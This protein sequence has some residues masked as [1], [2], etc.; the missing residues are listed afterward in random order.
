L[1]CAKKAL[2]LEVSESVFYTDNTVLYQPSSIRCQSMSS[3]ARLSTAFAD[4]TM[5][6]IWADETDHRIKPRRTLKT[7]LIGLALSLFTHMLLV[8]ILPKPETKIDM[9]EAGGQGPLQVVIAPEEK[10]SPPPAAS[11]PP[12][13]PQRPPSAPRVIAVPKPSPLMPP[14]AVAPDPAPTP[15]VVPPKPES[16]EPPVDFMAALN[17]RRAQRQAAEDAAA[18]ENASARAGEREMTASEKATAGFNRNMQSLGRGRD[19][20]SGVFQIQSKGTRYAAFSF[21]GWTTDRSRAQYQVIEVDAGIGGDVE[22]AIV[23]KMISLIREHYQGNFNWDSQR[24]GRVVVLSARKE[25]NAGLE[26]FIMREFPEL[27]GGKSASQNQTTKT[28]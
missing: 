19:G 14:V 5:P 24:L 8:V 21:R 25:D 4:G 2:I 22:L 18:S 6:R 1:Y 10:A 15:P 3:I 17:A 13:S 26:A 12:P 11:S 23:R 9:S 16:R 20:T 27:D 28:N 7:L